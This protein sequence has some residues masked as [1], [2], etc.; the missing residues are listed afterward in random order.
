MN[1]TGDICKDKC[2]RDE[3]IHTIAHA[4]EC[5][6][7]Y[8]KYEKYKLHANRT[9]TFIA[10]NLLLRILWL[11][12]K[13]NA[14]AFST[15]CT[16]RSRFIVRMMITT[17]I[18]QT[19]STATNAIISPPC[20]ITTSVLPSW[21]SYQVSQK[22]PLDIAWSVLQLICRGC[23]CGCRPPYYLSLTRCQPARAFYQS[24][25]IFIIPSEP[26]NSTPSVVIN[27]LNITIIVLFYLFIFLF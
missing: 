27:S 13:F 18:T 24:P 7:S 9:V 26:D 10:A 12:K 14:H 3:L 16:R 5:R 17:M 6:V 8:F 20:A 11:S 23:C 2:N 1:T 19:I 4:I 15:H 21:R 25:F 22:L